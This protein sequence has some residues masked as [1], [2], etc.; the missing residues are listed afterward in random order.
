MLVMNIFMPKYI[1]LH[2]DSWELGKKHLPRQSMQ[3]SLVD[4]Q[5]KY[6]IHIKYFF[7]LSDVASELIE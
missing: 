2:L 3:A 5:V 1:F 7:H 4:P 6:I